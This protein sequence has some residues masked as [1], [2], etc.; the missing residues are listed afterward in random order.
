MSPQDF[1]AKWGAPDGVPGPAF[2]LNE[3]QGAQ[4]HFLD[5]CELLDVPKPGSAKDYLFEEKGAVIGGRTGYADVFMRGVFVW[6]NKAPGGNLDAAFRQ[7]LAY[8][9][10]MSSPPI[11][12]VS[13]RL[14]IRIHTQFTG[15]PTQTHL[16][17]LEE[18]DQP[19]K[20]ALLRR[21]W[22]EPESFKPRE[23]SR[24]ITEAAARNFAD[25]AKSL[26]S[27]PTG[28]VEAAQ[29]SRNRA[30]QVAH[31]LTQ[32]LFCFFAEDV[33]LLPGRMFERLVKNKQIPPE[34]LTQGLTELFATMGKGGLY[35]V[36]DIPRFNGNLFMTIDVPQLSTV[37]VAELRKAASLNW[38]AI[39][40]SIIG[41]LFERGLDPDKRSQLGAHYTDT[42]TIDRLIDPV[43]R[44]PLLEKWDLIA[45]EMHRLMARS[46]LRRRA[47]YTAG[48]RHFKATAGDASFQKTEAIF[49]DWLES[50]KN[51][52]VLD[53]ACGS[54]NFLYL[55]L[56][57]LK[58]IELKSHLEAAA[59]GLDR[60]NDLVTGP[61]NV[62]GIELNEYAAELARV[63]VWIG[64]LQW[65]T[66][67]GYEFKTNP[68]LE[69]LDHIECR[70]AL[71]SLV[72]RVI[73][74][75]A[76]AARTPE[77]HTLRFLKSAPTSAPPAPLSASGT[78]VE[79]TQE[80][81]VRS[82]FMRDA[83]PKAA[84]LV[85]NSAMTPVSGAAGALQ[86]VEATWPKADVVIGN[87]PFL[88]GSKKRRELGDE[89]FESLDTVFTGRVPAGADLVCYWFEKARN[90]IE[91]RGLN[92][93]G[94]VATNSIRGGANRKVLDAI[95]NT[96]RIYEAWSDETWVNNGAAVRVSLVCFGHGSD[97][98]LDGQHLGEIHSDLTGTQSGATSVNLA[99]AKQLTPNAGAVF[100]GLRKDGPL[101]ISGQIARGWLRL[102]NPNGKS[103]A[104]V[105]YPL[106][107]GMDVTRRSRDGW[108]IDTG[109]SLSE[110]DAS[111]FEA[112]FAHI[113]SCVK[114]IRL[115]NND[116]IRRTFWWRF[117]RN[118][119]QL[120][121]SLKP[122][123]RYI[124]T[125]RVSKHRLFVFQAMPSIPDTAT[126]AITRADDTT[127]GVLHSRFHEL[128]SLRMCT[129][130]GVGNDPRYTPTTCFETFPFPTGLTPADTAHQQTEQVE[131]GALIPAVV[132]CA[133][134]LRIE[135]AM[136]I[137]LHA[138]KSQ[139]NLLELRAAAIQIA[140]AAKK[141]ND[142]REAWLNPKEWTH[143]V[144]EVTPLGMS[145]SPY[146]DRV[147]PKPGISADDL[148]ALQK[149][150]LT[151]L[152]NLRPQ[153]LVMA[154]QQLDLA[155][156]QAYGWS[157]YSAGMPDEEIL[158]RLL[159]LNLQRSAT[160]E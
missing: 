43:L 17:R 74:P 149:R 88:G 143:R 54:G 21:I 148:K 99:D 152:Y 39:D 129:W 82:E 76:W 155:V 20:L 118:G 4:S 49:H 5:L 71:L 84:T 1:I 6:E 12:V 63:T 85:G 26:Q 91:S 95:C 109:E 46:K 35:G 141:L 138:T 134:G 64:E 56:K 23:T 111:L 50:L 160:I 9:F 52:R 98:Y 48:R 27:R 120:R 86:A 154:H 3:E 124:N 96:T 25:L 61:H 103:N 69:S 156:A 60:Q 62:L 75:G 147:E 57:C 40:V 32:C 47:A 73:E 139:Q 110:Q 130:L 131:G 78:G 36:D 80:S 51:Y 94:L 151:N 87:P 18:L 92:S 108:V 97:T 58:D 117:G 119:E 14:T 90:E 112:P 67:H 29:D 68:V 42:A 7:L 133:D 19:D 128:W 89:Y 146:P 100:E 33:G 53:P 66:A 15:H 104:L 115:Q 157:D 142:L 106:I 137:P 144:P 13:D 37:D 136:T 10:A 45:Q 127:F 72:V 123:S 102:P 24:D 38:S 31:F 30:K 28:S 93:A 65:R 22:N 116:R 55:G 125:P 113:V 135:S 77:P 83:S 101:D 121:A 145:K 11:L 122:L 16:I 41:T 34:R 70:D 44:R 158:K 2:A 150:T 8:S 132:A 81:G 126:V 107:N 59:L 153:W 114:P 140:T 79:A 105:L 159:A